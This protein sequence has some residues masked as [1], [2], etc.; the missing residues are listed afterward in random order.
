MI[1]TLSNSSAI[2]TY[3]EKGQ[4]D[5]IGKRND[6]EEGYAYVELD[7]GMILSENLQDRSFRAGL[8]RAGYKPTLDPE[9]SAWEW[10]LMDFEY[11]QTP[12]RHTGSSCQSWPNS[13]LHTKGDS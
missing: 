13:A 2:Q 4:V 5:Y 1:S 9:A 8:N 11:A 3:S 6:F 7:A 10:Y 12:V